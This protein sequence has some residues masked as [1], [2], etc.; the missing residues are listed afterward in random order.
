MPKLVIAPPV[1][2]STIV[3][4][5]LPPVPRLSLSF[6]RESTA[7]MG[8]PVK[9]NKRPHA[10]ERV[11]S[12]MSSDD[13]RP[14]KIIRL[15]VPGHKLDAIS[16]SPPK[17]APSPRA[18]PSPARNSTAPRQP[19]PSNAITVASPVTVASPPVQPW[20]IKLSTS[21]A[22]QCAIS[23]SPAPKKE[24]KPLPDSA[25]SHSS[26]TPTPPIPAK[27]P[28]FVLKLKFNSASNPSS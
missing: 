5:P 4:S 20:Q 22:P 11:S 15:N 9:T 7:V 19:L 6:S 21:P 27:N 8:P 18:K 10:P 26:S 13:Q 14:R 16:R 24:R 1:Q 2:A 3:A 17:P 23:S 25:P 12:S 28:K